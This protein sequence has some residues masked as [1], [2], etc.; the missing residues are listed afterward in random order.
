LL[1]LCILQIANS[2]SAPD[3]EKLL[4]QISSGDES[5]IFNCMDKALEVFQRSVENSDGRPDFYERKGCNFL[6][7]YLDCA[8]PLMSCFDDD[9]KEMVA[10]KL[11]SN[12]EEF[13]APAMFDGWDPSK[14]PALQIM[15]QQ[16]ISQKSS[17]LGEIIG[18]L[19]GLF[20][21]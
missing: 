9:I 13:V 15:L 19:I 14:C 17:F 4:L 7:D 11:Y 20:F 3:C 2:E 21:L 1:T 12:Y 10:K 5:Y 6:E 16:T 18:L 8:A